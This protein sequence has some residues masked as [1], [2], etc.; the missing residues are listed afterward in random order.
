MVM[1]LCVGV[2]GKFNIE[3]NWYFQENLFVK[4]YHEFGIFGQNTKFNLIFK[5]RARFVGKRLENKIE[6]QRKRF[7]R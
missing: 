6:N 7:L 2:R 1:E 4:I 5:N 3:K